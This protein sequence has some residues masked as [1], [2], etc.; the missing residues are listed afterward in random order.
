MTLRHHHWPVSMTSMN[1]NLPSFCA[2]PPLNISHQSDVVLALPTFHSQKEWLNL[3]LDYFSW[4]KVVS[5]CIVDFFSTSIQVRRFTFLLRGV[6]R[7]F[8]LLLSC[9]FA[10]QS[11]WVTFI[12]A[13]TFASRS[14]YPQKQLLC[15]QTGN[16]KELVIPT[17]SNSC[18]QW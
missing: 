13:L 4:W 5:A 2:A 15:Q 3:N 8:H 9:I 1:P 12:Q 6:Y 18:G 17:S 14:P 7:V 11:N 16:V 10:W